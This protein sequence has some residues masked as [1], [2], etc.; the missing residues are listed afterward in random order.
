MTSDLSQIMA[1]ESEGLKAFN[2]VHSDTF[3]ATAKGDNNKGQQRCG[4]TYCNDKVGSFHEA[5]I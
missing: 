1:E 4:I 3:L 5:P 2:Q